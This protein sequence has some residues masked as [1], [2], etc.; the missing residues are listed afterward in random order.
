MPETRLT[1][2]QNL[3]LVGFAGTGKTTV[4]RL[5]AA[6]L[7]REF[8]DMDELIASRLDLSIPGIFARF[9][10]ARFR[11]EERLAVRDLSR[12]HGLVVA[13][14]GG[15]ILDRKNLER[16][17]AS[18][19]MVALRASPEVIHKRL[20]AVEPRPLLDGPDPLARIRELKAARKHIYDAVPLQL[21][22]DDLSPAEVADRVLV[23]VNA[24]VEE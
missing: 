17:A 6:R 13:A 16:L 9:G 7:G 23:L 10:E 3:I 15:A 12:R 2:D 8:V 20:Q 1:P 14:G 19:V 22:T 18:G 4:G 5:V 24:V 11:D 21:A